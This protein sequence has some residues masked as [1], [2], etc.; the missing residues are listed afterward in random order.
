M[1]AAQRPDERAA[2]ERRYNEA[3]ERAVTRGADSALHN[4]EAV[5]N[6]ESQAVIARSLTEV[7][8]LAESDNELY[9]TFYQLRN[10]GVRL[11]EGRKW[12]VLRTLT[13]DALFWGYKEEIRFAALTLNNLGLSN[14]GECSCVLLNDSIAHRA[15]VFEENSVL[16]MEHHDIRLAKANDLPRGYRATWEDRAKLCVA[17]LGDRIDSTTTKTEYAAI[18]LRNGETSTDDEFV[19][20]HVYGPMTARTFERIILMQGASKRRGKAS[21]PIMRALQEKLAKLDV[22]LEMV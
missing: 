4:F 17:K 8:R 15:S 11:P 9:A 10:A 20:V 22:K 1:R 2:L 21:R 14:Y 13:D 12:D 16:F 5:V 18:L 19:E 3:T 7:Q 6:Q